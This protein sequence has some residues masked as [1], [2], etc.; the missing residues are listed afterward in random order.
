MKHILI[1]DDEAPVRFLFEKMLE[2][3]SIAC[4]A[5]AKAVL[6]KPVERAVLLSAAKTILE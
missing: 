4:A 5:G 2:Q 1:I 3:E 6:E